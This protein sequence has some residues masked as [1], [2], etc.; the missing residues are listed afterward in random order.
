MQKSRMFFV[1]VFLSF[2]AGPLTAHAQSPQSIGIGVRPDG[3]LDL[4]SSASARQKRGGWARPILEPPSK[5]RCS[6]PPGPAAAASRTEA[7]DPTTLTVL[8]AWVSGAWQ[9]I[10]NWTGSSG[11]FTVSYSPTP[12]FQNGVQTLQQGTSSTTMTQNADTS[13]TLECFEVTDA[14]VISEPVQGIGYD[15]APA[16]TVPTFASAF[17]WWGQNVTLSAS[18]LDPI[19]QSNVTFFYDLPIRAHLATPIGNGYASD[20][21][22][23]IPD[24]SR[25]AYM[26]VQA[27]GRTSPPSPA[28]VQYLQLSPPNIGPYTNIR[29]VSYARATGKVW[30]AADGVVQEA[31]IF[32]RT[33]ATG[34][35][36]TDLYAPYI[37]RVTNSGQLMIIDGT[38]GVMEIFQ[39][40]V[41]TGERTH[42]A[43]T[44]DSSFTGNIWP[45]G[46][47]ADPDGSA[48][49]VADY[50]GSH[51]VKIPA[52]AGS[53][54]TIVD[55]W[56]NRTFS[57]PDPCG[58]DVTLGH[59]VV[60]GTTTW[61]TWLITGQY[62]SYFQYDTTSTPNSLEI[63]R[64]V[65]TASWTP[66]VYSD[67]PFCEAFNQHTFT[68]P[69]GGTATPKYHGAGV[70]A[71]N[72]NGVLVLTPDWTYGVYHHYPQNVIINNAG[73]D[74]AYPS[75][76]Q[77]QDKVI[78]LDMTGWPGGPLQLRLIDPSDAS[79]YAPE[80]G[81]PSQYNSPVPPYEANDDYGPADSNT[82][83]DYGL[84]FNADGSG[85]TTTPLIGYPDSNFNLT[86]YL[87]V[88]AR[89]SGDNYQ[90]EVTKC[91]LGNPPT[92]L[93]QRIPALSSVYTS[94]KRVYVE[95]HRMFR[96]GGLLF[97]NAA[98]NDTSVTI[99]RNPDDTRWDNL[100][101]NDKIAIFDTATPYEGP[102]D[103]AYV[104]TITQV[105]SSVPHQM[106]VTLVTTPGGSTPYP[107]NYAYTASP[108]DPTTHWPTFAAPTP[109][110]GTCAGMGVIYSTVQDPSG[111]GKTITDTD[112]NQING[113]GSAFYD[114]DMRD[115]E[116]PFDDAYVEFM[117]LRSGMG[118]LPYL[119]PSFFGGF[120]MASGGTC[121]QP[122]I[123]PIPGYDFIPRHK[124][125]W[126]WFA[127]KGL[128]NYIWLGGAGQT[129]QLDSCPACG[130]PQKPFPQYFGLT[131]ADQLES[132]VHVGGIGQV[133]PTAAQ[134]VNACQETTNHE[135]GHDYR[136]NPTNAARHDNRCAWQTVG[137][138]LCT[139]SDPTC[140]QSMNGCLMNP[141]RDLWT[142][143]HRLDRFNL[144]CGDS[145][146][147]NGQP[148]CC[149][150]G[151]S[152]CTEP[153]NGAIR[154]LSDPIQGASP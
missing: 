132:F 56:G 59:Q 114:A 135:L 84:T 18:Y 151:D 38:D 150:A 63:D 110:A 23:T 19:P 57:F 15:P 143:H 130:D 43:Y 48:C 144:L 76:W 12:S 112:S 121:S 8:K 37:S 120:Q 72:T 111:S 13:K 53:G 25:S 78:R 54:S 35:T 97:S 107:L 117:G 134:E 52:G 119:A 49:Y 90:V 137:H 68:T 58:M 145:G 22:F 36:F 99:Y 92:P 154:V 83:T 108:P 80:G 75:P 125:A 102:H 88:P 116:Q 40:D 10:L 42:Y 146:C 77:Q 128:S 81:F 96:R 87:K 50:N 82:N 101:P 69:A 60:L 91:A 45:S 104:G 127:N 2:A 124:F 26:F 14:S 115:I 21:T 138:L 44:H 147:P 5:A 153:G 79:G 39:V 34:T 16:P 20:A 55:A 93:P 105:G 71:D 17:Y 67:S 100:N 106:L 103:E 98:M 62:S 149:N 3:S 109:P 41:S 140:D 47:A 141:S 28:P 74:Q 123:E 126:I 148:G 64:D 122:V 51:V 46:I 136:V 7:A 27:H 24:D 85:A 95:R 118:A 6:V 4:L 131:T 152:G 133:C 94:W 70:W 89:Y 129:A 139:D 11:P 29:G 65:A 30:V 32:L 31:D 61:Q 66:W 113:T 73:Q 142:S 1:V 86:A 9:L 33:P